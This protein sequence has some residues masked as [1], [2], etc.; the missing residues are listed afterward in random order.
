[1]T[2]NVPAEQFR[3]RA[4]AQLRAEAARDPQSLAR[5]T[6]VRRADAHSW[7]LMQAQH[8][9][10][11]EAAYGKW[12][13]LI[14]APDDKLR[15]A[16]ARIDSKV[17]SRAHPWARASLLESPWAVGKW[18]RDFG[19]RTM[20][21]AELRLLALAFPLQFRGR[22]LSAVPPRHPLASDLIWL[23]SRARLHILANELRH[24]LP[25]ELSDHGKIPM[26]GRLRL[27]GARMWLAS[28]ASK[29]LIFARSRAH[30]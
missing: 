30:G 3:K 5:V 7:T 27:G 23:G 19:W 9:L 24:H 29:L 4:E 20:L 26:E 8:A 10:A 18:T 16:L 22:A 12:N 13:E 17:S 1:M 6:A 11:V 28:L 2:L 15:E 25:G 21:K 14:Q